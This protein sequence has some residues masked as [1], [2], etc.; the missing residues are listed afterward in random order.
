MLAK[1]MGWLL[2]G[3]AAASLAA[4]STPC[5]TPGAACA[6][7]S[8]AS[9]SSI[10]S[11]PLP[12]P[13]PP[14]PPRAPEP[15]IVPAET[16]AV[17]MPGSAAAQ[18][19]RE[20]PPDPAM[21]PQEAAMMPEPDARPSNQ[22]VRI[23]LLLPLRSETLG[24]AAASLRDGFMAAWERDKSNIEV[25]VIET[26]DPAREA[27][28]AYARA[29]ERDIVVGPLARGAVMAVAGS[30]LVRKPTI[31]LNM[32]EPGGPRLPPQ[33]LAMGLSIEEEAR[34]VAQWAAAEQP[35][36][37]ALVVTT[38]TP[39]QRR[40][41]AAFSAQWQ[42]LSLK[43]Q[44]LELG[45]PNG[46]LSDPELTALRARLHSQ[47]PG[48]LF[49]A[50]GADQAR[51]LRAALSNAP[52]EGYAPPPGA[53][54][55]AIP[56]LPLYGTSSLNAGAG[57][58]FATQDLDGVRLLDL[59]WQVQRDHPAVMV[60]PRPLSSASGGADMDR[61]YALGIDAFRVAREVAR[62]PGGRFHLDGVTGK[63][64]VDFGADG[65]SFER[66]EQAAV[67]RNGNPV[68]VQP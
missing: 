36:A 29:S 58:N 51:Q 34:Q 35:G 32:P 63:I 60:Y 23:A 54:T 15:E 17:S 52:L 21:S 42:R 5:G 1:S 11:A 48:L 50:L 2:S 24:P 13:P 14:L 67:Y 20:A 16:F 40:V 65:A 55:A 19:A 64:T 4:C 56:A 7:V 25:D 9:F 43:S 68:P 30:K 22:V 41:A 45:A 53:D 49:L 57:S 38:A 33:M 26:G 39:W 8:S 3:L 66:I 28:D 18:A 59:P 6:P 31:A 46:Y 12:P 27:L 44:T 61:L 62:Q 10:I 47:P 37:S